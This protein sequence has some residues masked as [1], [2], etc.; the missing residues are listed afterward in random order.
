MARRPADPQAARVHVRG[1]GE[2]HGALEDLDVVVHVLADQLHLG[3]F[4]D[5]LARQFQFGLRHDL[6]DDSA[7]F[8]KG[9]EAAVTRVGQAVAQ[10][11][12]EQAQLHLADFLA[13]DGRVAPGLE[14]PQQP[15]LG[16]NED[17]LVAQALQSLLAHGVAEFDQLVDEIVRAVVEVGRRKPGENRVERGIA[18]RGFVHNPDAIDVVVETALEGQFHDRCTDEAGALVL[19]RNI[20]K[21]AVFILEGEEEE[22]LRNCQHGYRLVAK[23]VRAAYT[24]AVRTISSFPGKRNHHLSM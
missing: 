12:L 2:R 1:R 21:A 7:G 9:H 13:V 24:A 16:F 23:N 22:L 4:G 14:E 19:K 8:G 18:G 11:H 15:S 5:P 3:E 10:Q 17:L 6:A 20:D